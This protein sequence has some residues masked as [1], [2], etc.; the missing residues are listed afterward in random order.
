MAEESHK[1]DKLVEELKRSLDT[2][3]L[4]DGFYSAMRAA[5][6]PLSQDGYPE[7][8]VERELKM[9]M[10]AGEGI[11]RHDSSTMV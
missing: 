1:F 4:E 9:L 3:A 2:H 7:T 8:E 5:K 11:Y 10:R 6:D